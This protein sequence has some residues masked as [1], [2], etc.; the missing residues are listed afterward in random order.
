[1][2]RAWWWAWLCVGI[3]LA[4]VGVSLMVVHGQGIGCGAFVVGDGSTQPLNSCEERIA[5]AERGFWLGAG[6][7]VAGLVDVAAALGYRLGHRRAGR[8]TP[9]HPA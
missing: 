4:A 5:A 3:A 1:M 8:A 7:T 9:S 2:R 6:L